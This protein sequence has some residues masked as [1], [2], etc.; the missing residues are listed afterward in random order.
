[1]SL[2]PVPSDAVARWKRFVK[3]VPVEPFPVFETV[4]ENV[5]AVPAVAEVGE[6]GPAVKS[7]RAVIAK[8]RVKVILPPAG[9]VCVAEGVILFRVRPEP[10]P[11]E[12]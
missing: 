12:L 4:A 7:G 2:A 10:G 9:R 8:L 11:P 3:P 6:T 1:M 5:A